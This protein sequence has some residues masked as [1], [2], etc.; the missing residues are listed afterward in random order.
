MVHGDGV[1][2]RRNAN[3]GAGLRHPFG[4]GQV[5]ATGVDAAVDVDL[6]DVDEPFRPLLHGHG[7]DDTHGLAHGFA[8]GALQHGLVGRRQAKAMR[9]PG[10]DRNG[11]TV[12]LDAFLVDLG[13]P[14]TRQSV[15]GLRGHTQDGNRHPEHLRG[16]E[17]PER[18]HVLVLAEDQR[19][20]SSARQS[21]VEQDARPGTR[22]SARRHEQD[23]A[24]QEDAVQRV[25]SVDHAAARRIDA[26]PET[27]R[28]PGRDD[29]TSRTTAQNGSR[30][31]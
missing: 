18:Q 24:R 11:E 19:R 14:G 4:E 28:F 27:Q 25:T 12:G 22:P 2:G 1:H 17:R 3:R 23:G 5:G 13:R 21:H 7:D 15:E 9:C 6:G 8:M 26:T 31:R 29:A 10:C 16:D 20:R 30:H